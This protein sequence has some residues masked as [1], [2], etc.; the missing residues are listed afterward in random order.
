MCGNVQKMSACEEAVVGREFWSDGFFASTVGKYGS[1]N[2]I[3][4]YVKNQGQEYGVLYSN[5]QLELL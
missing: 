5:H 1:E 4:N 2:M 3:G